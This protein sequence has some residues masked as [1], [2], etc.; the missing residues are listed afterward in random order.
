MSGELGTQKGEHRGTT[1]G[2]E[3]AHF[4]L[5]SAVMIRTDSAMSSAHLESVDLQNPPQHATVPSF[6]GTI[7]HYDIYDTPSPSPSAVL[8]IPGFW[9]DR[10]H[11][12]MVRLAR[13][14][15]N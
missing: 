8:V 15:T 1:G 9:R 2:T 12:S 5:P 14:L 3:G 13:F 4:G 11:P 10:R 6:D 7:I